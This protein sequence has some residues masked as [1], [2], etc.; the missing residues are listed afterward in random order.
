MNNWS[1]N[2]SPYGENSNYKPIGETAPGNGESILPN[3][4]VVDHNGNV[5]GYV[6]ANGKIHH[7]LPQTGESNNENVAV[8]VLGGTAVA[9]GLIGLTGV[10]R[11]HTN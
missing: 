6:D 2:R 1:N 10:K 5:V 11:R 3:G 8:A 9:L 4:E 7:T